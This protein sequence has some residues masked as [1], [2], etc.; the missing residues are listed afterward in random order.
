M[1]ASIPNVCPA[2]G[3]NGPGADQGLEALGF[4]EID[5]DD[6]F[7]SREMVVKVGEVAWSLIRRRVPGPWL[8]AEFM[9]DV[10]EGFP[11]RAF[12]QDESGALVLEAEIIGQYHAFVIPSGQWG[13]REVPVLH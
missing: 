9:A 10:V 4:H 8:T 7:L 11:Q 13:V 1:A 6:V 3:P 5:F 2:P 12:W